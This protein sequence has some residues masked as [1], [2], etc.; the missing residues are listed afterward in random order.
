MARERATWFVVGGIAGFGALALLS[1]GVLILPIALVIAGFL[2]AAQIQGRPF[3]FIGAGLVYALGSLTLVMDSDADGGILF[4]IGG[5]AVALLGFAVHMR[6]S[7]AAAGSQ[8]ERV[9]AHGP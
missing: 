8:D 2:L 4:V 1:I 9:S 3:F 7:R 6:T 5:F